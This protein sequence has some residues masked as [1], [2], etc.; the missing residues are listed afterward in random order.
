M[1]SDYLKKPVLSKKIESFCLNGFA[2]TTCEMQ[3]KSFIDLGWRKT[4]EDAVICQEV[5]DGVH[6][7]AV[8]DG[9]GG[10]EVSHYI[11]QMLPK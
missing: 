7:F 11:A 9:H 10:P 3:G 5:A 4:M 6:L 8:L 2:Y 1:S